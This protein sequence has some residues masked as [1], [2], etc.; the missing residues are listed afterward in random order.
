MEKSELIQKVVER[1]LS[2]DKQKESIDLLTKNC[3]I[4][5]FVKKANKGNRVGQS[6]YT[7]CVI[8]H[9]KMRD[10]I[11]SIGIADLSYKDTWDTDRGEAIA[12]TRAVKDWLNS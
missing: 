4:N 8:R 11:L 12:L 5:F 7:V 3:V 6:Q 10:V 9:K 1:V 2:A